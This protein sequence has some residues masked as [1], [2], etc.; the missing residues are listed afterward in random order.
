MHFIAYRS[1]SLILPRSAACA[2]IYL[3]SRRRNQR[4]GLT[5]YLHHEDGYFAQ[6][7]EG[8]KAELYEVFDAIRCDFRHQNVELLKAGQVNQR[9]LPNWDMTF[10]EKECRAY[11]DWSKARGFGDTFESASGDNIIAFLSID[12][13]WRD[14]QPLGLQHSQVC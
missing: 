2:E 14:I 4:S 11:V 8:A 7:L 1:Q 5:G 13:A 3:D 6:Y 10:S 12:T 9:R